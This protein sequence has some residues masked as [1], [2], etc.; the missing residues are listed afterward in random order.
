M[1]PAVEAMIPQVRRR[2]Q[3]RTK[4]TPNKLKPAISP[5]TTT[6]TALGVGWL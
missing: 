5:P 4:P 2:F 1:M 6:A 3:H